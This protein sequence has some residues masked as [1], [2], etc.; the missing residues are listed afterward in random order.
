MLPALR[1]GTFYPCARRP[2]ADWHI[3]ASSKHGCA[4]QGDFVIHMVHEQRSRLD[5]LDICPG[6]SS[7]E[8]GDPVH[9]ASGQD[10]KGRLS[11]KGGAAIAATIET[12]RHAIAAILVK[13]QHEGCRL[14]STTCGVESH[15]LVSITCSVESHPLVSITC[16]VKSRLLAR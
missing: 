9:A 7:T 10:P 2:E 6:C 12:C 1:L 14:V 4:G 15:L 16:G 13:R 3:K 11:A 5:E 8:L